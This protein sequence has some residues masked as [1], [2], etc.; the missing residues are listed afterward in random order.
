MTKFCQCGRSKNIYLLK[1]VY[2]PMDTSLSSRHR[3]GIQSSSICNRLWMET[4]CRDTDI[5]LTVITQFNVISTLSRTKWNTI[6]CK[7]ST[8][9][10]IFNSDES[11][12]NFYPHLLENSIMHKMSKKNQSHTWNKHLLNTRNKNLQVKLTIL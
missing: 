1:A 7:T 2:C 11:F 12:Y 8:G 10:E 4:P 9:I 6:I 3:F 5:D